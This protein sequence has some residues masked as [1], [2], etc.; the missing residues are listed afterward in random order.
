M[1]AFGLAATAILALVGEHANAGSIPREERLRLL[2]E[3]YAEHVK[4]IEAGKIVMADGR[5]IA[6]DDGREKTFDEKLAD[7]DIE[8]MLSQ[9]YP[10]VGCEAAGDLPT[11]FD[12]GRIRNETFFKS[13]YGGSSE[14]IR[15]TLITIDWFGEKI[16]VNGSYGIPEKLS[17]VVRELAPR[18][19]VLK[20]YLIP[21]AGTFL[22]RPI[23][24][25]SRLSTHSFG[26]ALDISTRKTEYWRW[27]KAAPGAKLAARNKLPVE[28][29]AAFERHGFISGSK[30]YHFD[31]MHFEYRPEL[32]AIGMRAKEL[33]CV[34]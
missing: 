24:G 5:E 10:V 9:I 18:L 17:A 19:P 6:I 14:Q 21:T 27:A 33:G 1:F 29:V 30:W 8:D 20:D 28:I 34:R 11:D 31:T 4:A 15:K 13:I 2:R 25:T 12:P 23:A 16:A 26:I 32:I 7:A 22:W 3:A